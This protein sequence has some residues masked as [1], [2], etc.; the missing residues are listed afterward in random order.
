MIFYVN[1]LVQKVFRF[2][3][4]PIKEKDFCEVSFSDREKVTW[5]FP[6]ASFAGKFRCCSLFLALLGW[7][8]LLFLFSGVLL[9]SK[10]ILL[11]LV[12]FWRFF[13]PTVRPGRSFC[14]CTV[15]L[16]RVLKNFFPT[17]EKFFGAHFWLAPQLFS[18]EGILFTQGFSCGFSLVQSC[19]TRYGPIADHV[20][21]WRPIVR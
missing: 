12:P 18:T 15:T 20:Q 2:L 11:I 17:G 7:L 16:W 4:N 3:L 9:V 13:G 6:R 1:W 8:F 5:F 14:T 21:S 19:S 10:V